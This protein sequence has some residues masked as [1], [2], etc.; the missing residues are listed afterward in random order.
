MLNKETHSITT[1]DDDGENEESN[2]NGQQVEPP[3]HTSSLL[4]INW[5]HT[6]GDL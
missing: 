3:R 6:R 2:K 4:R 5:I 1:I